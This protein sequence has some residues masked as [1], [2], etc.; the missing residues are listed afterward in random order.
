MEQKRCDPNQKSRR[1][2]ILEA[3][4]EYFVHICVMSTFLTAVLNE[5]EV[6]TALQGII[7]DIASLA[8]SLQLV[9]VFWVKKIYPCKR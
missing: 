8:C 5:M 1:L 4:V 9:A 2:Y 3:A 6:S 7:A